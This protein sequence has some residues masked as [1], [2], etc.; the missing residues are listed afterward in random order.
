MSEPTSALEAGAR[1][2]YAHEHI[3]TKRTP[4]WDSENATHVHS[5]W[6]E[7]ARVVDEAVKRY[8]ALSELAVPLPL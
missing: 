2:L 8:E 3:G 7:R 4:N 6:L 5:V 1:A